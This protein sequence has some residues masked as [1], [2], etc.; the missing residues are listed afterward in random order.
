MAR[1]AP[2]AEAG[3]LMTDSETVPE[4][5]KLE[6]TPEPPARREHAG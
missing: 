2:T 5:N 6:I 1:T 3:T 4:N